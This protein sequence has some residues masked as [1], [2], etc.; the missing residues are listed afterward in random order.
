MKDW[1]PLLQ[2]L[3]W[4]VFIAVIA[5]RF[6][7]PIQRFLNTVNK[8]VEQGDGFEYE[9]PGGVVRLPPSSPRSPSGPE[10]QPGA[11]PLL[12]AAPVPAE[13][14]SE[15]TSSETAPQIYMAHTS[16]RDRSLDRGNYRYH[17]IRIFLEGDDGD[18]YR[19]TRVVYHLHPTF[20]DPDR[21]VTDRTTNFELNTSAWGMFNLTA[22][23]HLKGQRNPLR[24]GRYLNF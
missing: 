20:Y 18:L 22:D 24:L 21:T 9:G 8:R 19:V 3:I 2:S 15:P 14:Q 13:P 5:Y 23:V 11:Q 16:R 4:P 6:R 1:I 10:P 7:A 12:E 17:R